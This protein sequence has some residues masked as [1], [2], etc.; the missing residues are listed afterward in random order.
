MLSMQLHNIQKIIVS[1]IETDYIMG[2]EMHHRH[3][4]LMTDKGKLD[5]TI[6]GGDLTLY[7][8][9]NKKLERGYGEGNTTGQ[10]D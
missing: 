1:E 7:D 4:R 10:T 3:L 8:W 2:E 6:H 5:L 9:E